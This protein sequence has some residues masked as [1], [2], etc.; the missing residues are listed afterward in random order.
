MISTKPSL[1]IYCD[2]G[3]R[4]NPGPA[5]IGF[6]VNLEE[7][8]VHSGSEFIGT[9]TNNVA[10]YMAVIAALSWLTNNH[11]NS[12]AIKFFLDSSLVVNQ[13]S[14][15]WKIKN[16]NLKALH[17]KA[18]LLMNKLKVPINFFLIPREQNS[19]ADALV[20]K[21]LDKHLGLS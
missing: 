15:N 6:V 16:Q 2:G 7:K 12:S 10:E 3:A 18:S 21:A 1:I 20:N 13:L 19:Q 14:N 5:G 9:T 4:G 8:N 11:Q 17:S